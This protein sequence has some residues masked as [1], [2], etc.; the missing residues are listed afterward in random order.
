[1]GDDTAP[2]DRRSAVERAVG[3]ALAIYRLVH[4]SD[5]AIV[6]LATA[7]AEAVGESV[8]GLPVRVDPALWAGTVRLT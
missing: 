3:Q 8:L 1:M 6:E 4:F 7:D 5:P 2:A